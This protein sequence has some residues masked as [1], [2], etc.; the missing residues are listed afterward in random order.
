MVSILE[1]ARQ[2]KRIQTTVKKPTA[3]QQARMLRGVSPKTKTGDLNTSE[4]LFNLAQKTGGTVGQKGKEIMG[5]EKS[6]F[7][8][9]ESGFKKGLGKTL[10][11]AQRVNYASASAVKN[12]IDDDPN[13]TFGGGL[14][15][16]IK[17]ITKHT[18]TDVFEE[19]GWQPTGWAGKAAKGLSGFALDVL[20]DPTTYVTFGASAGVK[21]GVK[22]GGQTVTKTLTKA[23][24]KA[25]RE[26]A[27][28]AGEEFG[29]EF[30]TKTL[31]NMAEKS[32]ELYKKF[33]D[34]GGVKFF[35]QTLISGGR[36][37]GVVKAIPGMTKLDIATQP[38]RNAIG[39]LFSRNVSAKF[40]KLPN[41]YIQ[42]QQKFLD[43]GQVKGTDALNQ[44]VEIAKQNKLTAAEAKI[45]TNAIENKLPLADP[46]LENARR[47]LEQG[48]GRNLKDEL[49]A[50]ISIG[51]LPNYVPHMLLDAEV[52][53]IPFKPQGVRVSLGAS[54]GRT[55]GKIVSED[56]ATV[57]IGKADQL[58]LK[59]I[60]TGE[61]I[62]KVQARASKT[63]KTIESKA[64]DLSKR[65]ET[66]SKIFTERISKVAEMRKLAVESKNTK[67]IASSQ[68]TIRKL[69]KDDVAE[70]VKD[71]KET[72]A[73][74]KSHVSDVGNLY[75][76]GLSHVDDVEIKP[77]IEGLVKAER[78]RLNLLIKDLEEKVLNSQG[79][80][81]L[82]KPIVERAT[83]AD[84][85]MG[86]QKEMV[87]AANRIAEESRRIEAI[88]QLKIEDI[89]AEAAQKREA[90][91]TVVTK[92][93][94]DI[95]NDVTEQSRK[96]EFFDL[97]GK[98][99]EG[100]YKK[101]YKSVSGDEVYKGQKAATISEINSA[102]GK[103]FFDPNI[104]N[105]AA[106]RS[107][108]SARAV[109][110]KEF[111]TEVAQKF[112][113]KADAAPT[114]YVKAGAKELEG[115]VF[116]PAIAE[117]IDKFG[118][119]F[120]A[121]E[122]TNQLFKAFDKAQNLWKASVTSIFPAFHGRNAIS[123]V[124]LN[125][126][127]IGLSALSPAKH[128]LSTVMLNDNRI[129]TKLE[130]QILKGGDAA[131]NLQGQLDTLLKKPVLTDDFGK[132]WTF[133]EI[134][135][136][137]KEKRVAFGDEFTGFL[138]IRDTIKDKLSTA[139]TGASKAKKVV[140]AVNPLS[141]QNLAFKAG[142]AVGNAVEQQAR[143][144]N[145]MTNLEKT[146]D[147]V[148]AAER[149]KQFL[150]DYTNLSDFEKN[151]MRRLIPFYTFTR[152]NLELQVTQ[153]AKQPGKLATQAK[154]F[155]NI[156]KGL[157]GATL[158]EEETKNLPSYLQEG[159]GIVFKRDGN[160]VEII[161]SL[162]T[163]I[164]QIFSALKD[165]SLLGSLSPIIAVPLQA[166]IGKHFFFE[167]DIK[168]VDDATAFKSAPQF[169][170]DY[171]GFTIRKKADGTD[172]YVALNPTRLFILQSIPPSSRVVQTIGQLEN[173]N[174]SGQLKILRLASGLKPY[175]V[176]LDEQELYAEKAKMRE[177]QD[178][179]DKAGVAP[180]MKRS[181][182]PKDN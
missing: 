93:I 67:V 87:S 110:S 113:T 119:R 153:L 81:F 108:A 22:I 49:K 124:F 30:I 144:L 97:V 150:F 57:A 126:L 114:G 94:N 151:V 16:G 21:V 82:S 125:Y 133:G 74:L 59:K 1:Q 84:K 15:S 99:A 135:K 77:I 34:Q 55:I 5:E 128:A 46:R 165:N 156:S 19:A 70:G 172:R 10:D 20:L 45:I 182:I 44:V 8:K 169:I 58:G 154:L 78:E 148:T 86:A 139:T 115:L 123:N 38:V 14:K 12:A 24:N 98:D 145:F 23:G 178:L 158:T 48:L 142:R 180:I 65:I 29:Q 40:G 35:G 36:I 61:M 66:R 63:I 3:L 62:G 166:A 130:K 167:R 71:L 39:S 69:L 117:Q 11:V 56:G 160:K 161:N 112:G 75:D 134:R 100:K 141:Q 91:S 79:D 181:F 95:L 107:V 28:K 102:F 18:Y 53:N 2:L 90:I 101:L 138:D 85:V 96:I 175:G 27:T 116:H 122:G 76:E 13:T 9:I 80:E 163:P 26:T 50:G 179:L 140:K 171:I 147:V 105:T 73:E 83:K 177:L 149:T 118:G 51:E 162:G 129:A 42:L 104:I 37:A 170:K 64:K 159:L 164:E 155:T 25:L 33:I 4:G 176:D 109:N 143:V 31:S 103:D 32:P 7:G 132:K 174:V 173:E 127:D 137:I 157:S 41:E 43:L 120:I 54:K 131:K 92:H 106:I 88:S 68:E 60:K 47:L 17:G 52:K 168:D 121:D 146:G 136:E 72:I 111:L 6:I 89:L 152:K